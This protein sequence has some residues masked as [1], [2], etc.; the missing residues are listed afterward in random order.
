MRITALLS[1]VVLASCLTF[2]A[3][4]P[5]WVEPSKVQ[6]RLVAS[7]DVRA[8]SG[9]QC[10][11]TTADADGDPFGAAL[12][13]PPG[14]TLA[15]D[16]NGAWSWT[17]WPTTEQQGIHYVTLQATELLVG[18]GAVLNDIVTFAVRVLP[19]NKPP[20]ITH[21]GCRILSR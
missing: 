5:A 9:V 8:G 18:Q 11:G 2:G 15:A 21:G 13:S 1:V 6:G 14:A 12:T 3:A 10:W 16:P 19:A 4:V 17:W 7:V 20:I